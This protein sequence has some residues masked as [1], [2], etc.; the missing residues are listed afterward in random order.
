MA[1]NITIA[2]PYAQAIF[3]LAREQGDLK[4]WSDMLQYAAAVAADEE[5]VAV[6]DSPRFDDSQLA[7]LF[8]EICGEKLNDAGKNMI[9]VLAENDRL[10]VLPEVAELFEA[11]RANVEGTIVAEVTSATQLN[12]AQQKSIAEA[13]KKRLGREVTLECSI[14]ESL[15]GGAIIRAGD[16]VID[17][18]VVGKLEKLAS[19]LAH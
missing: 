19:A 6:I 2:R 17:G 11:E 9:R 10:S 16:V 4:G 13:L 1:E 8:I 15:L 12:D 18:S 3:S 14:D 7:D 5:M